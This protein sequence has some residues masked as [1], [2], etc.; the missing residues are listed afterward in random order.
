MQQRNDVFLFTIIILTSRRLSLIPSHVDDLMRIRINGPEKLE[1]F[2]ALKY[3]LVRI[4]EHKKATIR[5]AKRRA[6]IFQEAKCVF[7]PQS[8]IL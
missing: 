4:K 1:E 8:T 6:K 2:S 3:A 7:L 5:H